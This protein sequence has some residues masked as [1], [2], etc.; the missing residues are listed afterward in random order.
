MGWFTSKSN[1]DAERVTELTDLYEFALGL[2]EIGYNLSTNDL[3][4][5]A[6]EYGVS[7]EQELRTRKGA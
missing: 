2:N 1:E 3:E 5:E 7:L 6:Q 4:Q